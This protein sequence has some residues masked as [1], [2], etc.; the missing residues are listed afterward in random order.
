MRITKYGHSCLHISEG[1]AS[2]LID[3]GAFSQGFETLSG[4]TA[5]LVTHQHPDHLDP[6][7]LPLLLRGNPGATLYADAG[8][9]DLLAKEGITATPVA[10]GDRLD[11]G[12]GV[13]VFAGDHAVIHRDIPVIPN[14]CYLVG[15]RLLH[16]GD[17][18]TVLDRPVEILALPTS[19]PW[20]A[21]KEAV[22]Y[23]RAVD[24]KAAIPIH[25]KLM[26][27]PAMVYG[28]LQRLGPADARW[29]NL[30][31]GHFENL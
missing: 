27:N 17:S 19:A 16:P 13:E 3:P 15:G 29:V 5:V 24:P 4:L 7:R 10:S 23:F 18:L 9:V 28:L 31:D 22:D 30:D 12:I 6:K 1:S 2:I 14:A 20:M 25:D 26:A 11:V 21:V 8:S